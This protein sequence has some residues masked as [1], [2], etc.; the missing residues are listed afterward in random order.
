MEATRLITM[1]IKIPSNYMC[2]LVWKCLLPDQLVSREAD[3]AAVCD[4]MNGFM[5]I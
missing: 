3:I 2:V 1:V 5:F 4:K